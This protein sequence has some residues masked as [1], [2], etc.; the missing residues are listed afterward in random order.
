MPDAT[1]T[2]QRGDALGE[3]YRRRI[4]EVYV[5]AF[6]DDFAGFSRDT[7]KL[8]DAFEHMLL[9]ERF[10]VALVDGEPAGLASLTSGAETLFDPRP[11]E[12]RRHLGPVRGRVAAAVIQRWF[13]PP[14]KDQRPHVAEIG[15]V[16]TEPAFQGRGVATA[17]LRH[18]LAL[19]AYSE[20]VLAEIKDTNAAALGLYAKLGFTIDE[21]RPMR[22]ARQAGFRELISMRLVQES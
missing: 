8:A 10:F 1:I 18:L 6:A 20:Y 15:F 7:S 12:I 16:S 21:R 4:T 2:V 13:M 11:A 17:L 19:P 3:P 5:R 22:F 14:A 9:L